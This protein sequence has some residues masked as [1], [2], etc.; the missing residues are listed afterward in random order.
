MTTVQ[1]KDIFCYPETDL[2]LA[3]DTPNLVTGPNSC[4]KTSLARVIAALVTHD[5]NPAGMSAAHAKA[6][7]RDGAA[8]GYA[9]LEEVVWSPP[10]GMTI[11]PGEKPQSLPHTVG[12]VDFL[13]ATRSKSDRSKVWE[14]LFLP[15]DPEAILRPRWKQSQQQLQ[16][17]LEQIK[18]EK[19]GWEAVANIY[20]GQKLQFRRRWEE[21]TG[22]RFGDKKA[23]EWKPDDWH[24]DLEG[25][26]EDDV[27]TAVTEASDAL[28][29][30]SVRQAVDQERIDKGIEARDVDVPR[31]EAKIE[32][33][34]NVLKPLQEIFEKK[35]AALEPLTAKRV[36]IGAQVDKIKKDAAALK[37]KISAAK[38]PAPDADCPHC[39]EPLTITADKVSK[40]TKGNFAE[41]KARAQQS[42]DEMKKSYDELTKAHKNAV[43]QEND[44]KTN[45]EMARRDMDDVSREINEFAG[46][47]SVHKR[48]AADAEL[49]V[50][51]GVSEAERSK[52][53]NA[54]ANAQS[55]L[56]AWRRNRDAAQ[57]YE[58]YVE[59]EATQKLLEA[60]GARGEH[61]QK[62]MENVRKCLKSVT[63]KTGW[64]PITVTRTYEVLSN[65]RP[66]Q[67][68]AANEQMKCQWALQTACA[69][70]K[71]PASRWLILD[72][73]DV[74]RGEDWDG[75]VT[76]VDAVHSKFPALQVVV[77]ATLTDTP[78]G[79]TGVPLKGLAA[80]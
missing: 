7:V 44:A 70:L 50:D 36:E 10:S 53:E 3:E 43:D 71:Q 39:G 11:P 33:R 31:V 74:L 9:A 21:I 63:D 37:T 57:A 17:V 5:P 79:W 25:L 1:I 23:A 16:A 52:L 28:R 77:C 27:M 69:M 22:Q 67:L 64:K 56:H 35:K 73:A 80:A 34:R 20:K 72:A 40:F 65:G 68:C 12:L 58:N 54:K 66:A 75:L 47:L 46:E 15:E 41:Q 24:V 30:I 61:M 6:Y 78:E 18:T 38:E 8:E 19:G 49:E 51:D 48:T 26:S 55:R 45:V 14:G 60:D 32:E 76:L 59:K 13:A 42:L 29:A 2:D 62:H 4:G